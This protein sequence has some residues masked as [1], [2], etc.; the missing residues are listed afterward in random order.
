MNL[1]AYAGLNP[2]NL[3]DP[4]GL[5]SITVHVRSGWGIF[6]TS[7]SNTGHAWVTVTN[8]DGTKVTKGNYP[9]P[10]H[11]FQGRPLDDSGTVQTESY[12]FYNVSQVDAAAAIQAISEFGYNIA[13]D[14]C[15]DRVEKALDAAAIS[16]PNL[17]TLGVS[18]PNNV[19]DWI[20]GRNVNLI[21]QRISQPG[22]NR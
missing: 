9:D 3:V 20:H 12:T 4:W 1:Y 6:S 15:A 2:I 17:N 18:T 13:S 16:Y 22:N 8:D 7:N 10:G 11:L 19:Y 5:A 14:N 21:N